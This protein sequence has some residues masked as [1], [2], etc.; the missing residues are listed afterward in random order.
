[1]ASDGVTESVAPRR[2]GVRRDPATLS[3]HTFPATAPMGGLLQDTAELRVTAELDGDRAVV[4][5]EVTNSGAGH[6]LPT[7]S[8]LRRVLLVVDA[9]DAA[10]RELTLEEGPVL[11]EWTD[12]LWERPGLVFAKVLEQLWT[13][14]K[15]T[16][17]FWTQTRLVEDTRIPARETRR[18]RHTFQA[19]AEGDVNVTARLIFRREDLSL[20]RQKGW[21]PA[22]VVME[23]ATLTVPGR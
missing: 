5:A 11:P 2:G 15:P 14:D 20:A 10:G 21:E 6:H 7:G 22:D 8:P 16:A 13:G 17:A 12:D 19:P 1:M 9:T 18:S 4:E 23:E 3:T